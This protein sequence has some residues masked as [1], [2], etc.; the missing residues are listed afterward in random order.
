MKVILL[1][2]LK[3]K[4][5]E[6]DVVEVAQGYAENYL[7]PKRMA[8]PATEGNLKQLE[9]RRHKIAEREA[10][11]ITDA[12]ALREAIDG[13]V[14]EIDVKIGDEGQLFGAVTNAMIAE[15][16][17]KAYGVEIDRKRIELGRPIKVA[18]LHEIVVSIY[19]DIFATIMVQVGTPE[20]LPAAPAQEA[21]A[22]G[23]AAP[24][25]KP[26]QASDAQATEEAPA[27]GVETPAEAD[28]PK[29]VETTASPAE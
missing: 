18:G 7:F 3:G 29:E 20:E 8:L 2:E 24:T 22:D 21:P 4:G 25:E 23:E 9:E 14:V 16:L 19:R 12:E 1:S 17:Q 27:E 28:E 10:T 26:T 5:G 6:G 15:A 11:R 13:K